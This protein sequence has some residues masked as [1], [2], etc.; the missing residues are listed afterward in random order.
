[1]LPHCDAEGLEPT[2]TISPHKG[3]LLH[4]DRKAAKTLCHFSRGMSTGSFIG[5]EVTKQAGLAGSR[6]E[7][8]VP[9]CN[10]G[11]ARVGHRFLVLCGAWI[12]N[13]SSYACMMGVSL[14]ELP[15][16]HP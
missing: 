2:G 9:P 15:S 8:P 10:F 7:P 1:M 4:R 12:L 11:I 3:F 13:S 6:R 14:T 16:P 5:L